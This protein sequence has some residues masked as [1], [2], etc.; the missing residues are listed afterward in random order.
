MHLIRIPAILN[1]GLYQNWNWTEKACISWQF[2]SRPKYPFHLQIEISSSPH[3]ECGECQQACVFASGVVY[4]GPRSTPAEVEP[5]SECQHDQGDGCASKHPQPKNCE[6]SKRPGQACDWPRCPRLWT[7]S[8]HWDADGKH[9]LPTCLYLWLCPTR[10]RRLIECRSRLWCV[11]WR[12]LWSKS[13]NS[14]SI[15]IKNHRW[16]EW[17]I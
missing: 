12:L 10:L 5:L 15:A 11:D 7:S 6:C 17:E 1:S 13:V 14:D 3:A 16:P 4:P 8:Q 9:S 2:N